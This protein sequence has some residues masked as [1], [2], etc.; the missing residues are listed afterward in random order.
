MTD[1]TSLP[2]FPPP[3]D[4]RPLRG[5]VLDVLLDEGYRPDIDDDGD[6]AVKV[7]GQQLYV[8]CTEGEITVLRVFGQWRLDDVD[9]DELSM[10]RA[11]NSVSSRLSV[12]KTTLGDRILIVS[13]DHLVTTGTPL[14]LVVTSS[15]E[16]VLTAVN[17]WH[18]ALG[19]I[20]GS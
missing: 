5:R 12:A 11:C 16:L 20:Q 9:A 15:L 17:L 19:E 1:P 4:Q 18:E 6:V 13:A 10:L 2:D 8:R 3:S 14:Q 7:Q